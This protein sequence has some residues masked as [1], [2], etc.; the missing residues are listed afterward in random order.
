VTGLRVWS[1]SSLV[2]YFMANTLT[3]SLKIKAN[4]NPNLTQSKP[5]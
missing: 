5:Y 1:G 4:I 2:V 3:I